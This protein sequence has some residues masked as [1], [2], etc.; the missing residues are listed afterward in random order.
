LLYHLLKI[1]ARLAFRIYV[2]N[3]RL[4]NPEALQMKGP[5]LIAANHPNSFLD[6]IIIATLFQKPVYSLARGDV[7]SNRLTSALLRA[8]HI[9]PVYRM[10]EG[11]ENLSQNY[12]TFEAC[13]NIFRKN[14]IVLI[15][16]E[17]LCINEWKLRPLMKGTARLA[18][19][20][21]DEGIPLTILPA[22]IN[23]HSFTRFGK[24]VHLHFG[25]AFTQTDLGDANGYGKTILAF[26]KRL[27]GELKQL[28]IDIDASGHA[29]IRRVFASG[30]PGTQTALLT[31][32]AITGWLLHA[33]LYYPIKQ[34][35]YRKALHSGHYDSIM[36]GALFL[37]YPVYLISAALLTYA[38]FGIF[39]AL[40]ALALMPLLAY[41]YVQWKER[42]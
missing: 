18:I 13:R 37:L 31:I 30:K 11:A 32:P 36:V 34:I 5:L 12:S 27:E 26:N 3:L 1:P 40:I 16:S 4:K 21:W 39:P 17:G 2:R 38:F 25:Q 33:P 29:S 7:F 15:F 10:R 19:S 42:Y 9:L 6:A 8:L 41:A 23:Y 20:S 24:H 35:V 28:V 14:G 22:A